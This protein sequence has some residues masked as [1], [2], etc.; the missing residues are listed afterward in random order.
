MIDQYRSNGGDN[1]SKDDKDPANGV[2]LR[3]VLRFTLLVQVCHSRPPPKTDSR[4]K[5]STDAV[6]NK[7]KSRCKMLIYIL[8]QS[9]VRCSKKRPAVRSSG[10]ERSLNGRTRG[11]SCMARRV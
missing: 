6:N 11:G 5:L 3:R 9:G 7:I 10:H 8:L 1:G 4:A 2:N